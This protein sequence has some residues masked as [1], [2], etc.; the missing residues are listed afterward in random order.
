M[1]NAIRT[2]N[3]VKEA[4]LIVTQPIVGITSVEDL[5]LLNAYYQSPYEKFDEHMSP[6]D[7]FEKLDEKYHS[8]YSQI[9]N[10]TFKL[11]IKNS[12]T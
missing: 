6:E 4:R 7:I 1:P 10:P 5:I 9:F 11:D 2:E 3:K 8:H 12:E